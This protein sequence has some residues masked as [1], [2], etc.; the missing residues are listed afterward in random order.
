MWQNFKNLYHLFQAIIAN[1]Y[2]GFPSRKLKVIGVTG[3]DGKTTT[4][5]LITHILK[6]NGKK[7]S[8]ISTVYAVIAGKEYDTGFHVTTPSPFFIQKFLKKSVD[9]QDKYFILETTSH[10]LDQNRVWGIKYYI[11]AITNITHEH[12]DYHK[13]FEDYKKTKLKLLRMSQFGFKSS[14]KISPLVENLPGITK[15][16]RYNYTLAYNVCKKLGLSDS[17]ILKGLVSFKLPKGR[18][19]MVYDKDFKVIIDFAHTPNAFLNLLPE[20]KKMIG[21]NGKIIHVFGAAG[22]RDFSKRPLMGEVSDRFSDYIILTEEDYRTENVLNIINQIVSGIKNKNKFEIIVNRQKAILK[23]ISIAKKG[24]VVVLTGK[25]HEKSLCRG[26]IEYPWS[27]YK[28]VEK[29]LRNL[30]I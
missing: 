13:N 7:T 26:K 2:Y 9:N 12:L 20:V 6:L 29:A 23:A 17:Q 27:E 19:E 28:A 8:F 3:T 11:G 14:K 25:S 1:F 22:L 16:N 5:Q 21:N 10:A 30:P 15:F 18:F 4:T 24:D